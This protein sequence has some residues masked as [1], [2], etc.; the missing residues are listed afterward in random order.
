MVDT[1]FMVPDDKI[2]RLAANYSRTADKRLVPIDD[3]ERSGFRRHADVLLRRRRT[4][5][6]DG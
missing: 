3:P 5:V 1:G 2:D 6:D 4:R